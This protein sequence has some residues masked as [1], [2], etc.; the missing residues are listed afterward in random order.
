MVKSLAKLVAL[1][2]LLSQ[3]PVSIA[4]AAPRRIVSQNQCAD[5]YLIALAD[6]NQIAAL[7]IYA[8][9]RSL[10][11]FA[12]EA[13][14]YPVIANGAEQVILLKPDLI[15]GNPFWRAESQA[16]L[17]QF[18]MP[19][20]DLP[21]ADSFEQIV[22]QTRLVAKAV[23]HPD[24]GETLIAQMEA[25]LAK[26]PAPSGPR[27]AVVH[28]QRRGF[29]TGMETLMDDMMQRLGLQNLASRFVGEKLARVPLELIVTAN[30]DYLLFT[31]SL[32]EPKD[33]GM[34]LLAHPVLARQFGPARILQVPE[35]LTICGGPSYP[36][37]VATLY[38]QLHPADHAAARQ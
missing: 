20:M 10:S 9:D 25:Q 12:K 26:I 36:A 14:R 8:R 21:T 3:A 30:P 31:T 29:V 34:E 2:I 27:P 22:E 17:K 24:R 6:R 16:M 33:L 18:N 7:T 37:A 13:Q 19:I 5:Q 1:L 35:A 4:E 11:Y 38:A 23:G 15:I 32:G 28:Y